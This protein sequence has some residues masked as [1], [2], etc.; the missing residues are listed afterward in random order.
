MLTTAALNLGLLT[1]LF[2][3]IGMIKPQW[4]LFFMDKPSRFIVLMVT[5]VLTMVAFTMFGEG[6]R[7]GGTPNQWTKVPVADAAKV[8]AKPLATVP[9]PVPEIQATVPTIAP[10]IAAPTSVTPA[11][12]TVTTPAVAPAT[13]E[14]PAK[15]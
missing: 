12:I 10:Q 2:F 1:I 8:E 5:T 7:Q 15:K 14:V 4:S 9:V 6:H 11:P 13:P 3:I